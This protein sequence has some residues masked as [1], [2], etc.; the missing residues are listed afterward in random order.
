[1]AVVEVPHLSDAA[2]ANA[3][4]APEKGQEVVVETPRIHEEHIDALPATAASYGALVLTVRVRD[5]FSAVP[6][7]DASLMAGDRVAGRQ[8][9]DLHGAAQFGDL[10]PGEYRL[11]VAYRGDTKRVVNLAKNRTVTVRFW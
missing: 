7:A 5:W 8:K 9:T 10:A 11:E 3:A 2:M 6:D 1:M 4:I